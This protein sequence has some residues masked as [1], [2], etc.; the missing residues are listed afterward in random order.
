MFELKELLV[1]VFNSIE[2]ALK[3]ITKNSR[4]VCF[5]TKDEKLVGVATDGDIRR[6]LLNGATLE[7]P[8]SE[9]MNKECVSFPVDID[10]S[11]IRNTF[12][13]SF[14]LIPL[15]DK[16]G[17]VVDFAD[18]SRN[19]NIPVL[20]PK[21]FGNEMMYVQDCI[22]TNWISSQG[23]Y[24]RMF[25]EKFQKM[26]TNFTALAVS[27]GTV[28]LHLALKAFG[29]GDGD[30]VI[31][32]DLTFAATINSVIHAS[33]E[34]VLCDVDINT[35]VIDPEQIKKLISPKTKAIIVVHLYGQPC[36]M[37]LLMEIALEYNL[38]V[39]E[40]CAEALGS[41]W[42]GKLVGTFGDAATFSFFGN[43]TITTGEGGMVIFKDL[44]TAENAKI[45]RDHGMSQKKRYWHDVVGYNYRMTNLQAAVGV[46][47][48]EFFE[49]ILVKKQEMA[50]YYDEC[51]RDII[52]KV[53]QSSYAQNSDS[54]HSQWLYSVRISDQYSIENLIEKLL[55][56]G[57]ESRPIFYPL[58]LMPPYI[59]YRRGDI[60]NSIKISSTGISLPSSVNITKG[61][62]KQVCNVL[63]QIAMTK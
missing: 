19:H 25:E 61:E 9:A 3:A 22:N 32:P 21:M 41:R 14:R 33:A 43:K 56:N 42:N 8:I 29:I 37:T 17:C 34:P 7:S 12:R 30:E 47:Q 16:N 20:E 46:A 40:D 49:E 48:M 58:H 4:G 60:K 52:P 6:A 50:L 1:N 11:V 24:V 23:K 26:H 18:A 35:W 59:K 15:L 27:N 57:I 10:E 44:S 53:V 28:A 13:D 51:L 62:I 55:L 38:L 36:D 54:F 5:I 39:I 45:L 2:D 63:R 31:V